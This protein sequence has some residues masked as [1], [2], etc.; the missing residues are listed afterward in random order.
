MGWQLAVPILIKQ[1]TNATSVTKI[2][3]IQLED[4]LIHVQSRYW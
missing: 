1:N 2:N 3:E 4:K